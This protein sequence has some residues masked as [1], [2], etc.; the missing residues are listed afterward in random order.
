[1]GLI[2]QSPVDAH[3]RGETNH[4]AGSKGNV[5][6]VRAYGQAVLARFSDIKVPDDLKGHADTFKKAHLAY[7]NASTKVDAAREKRDA[8][9]DAIGD[10]DEL[11]DPSVHA[12]ADAMVGARMG[13]RQNP[14]S[15][16]SK[17][18]P[19]A[20]AALAYAREPEAM[21]ELAAA[22]AKK[23]PPA[24]VK[25]TVATCL[26]HAGAIEGGLKKLTAPQAAYTKALADRDALLPDWTKALRRLKKRAEAVWEDEAG[27]FKAVFAKVGAV[28]APKKRR[29]PPGP[30]EAT[31]TPAPE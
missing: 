29:I 4:M 30:P 21:R 26:K 23:S 5:G 13:K 2:A 28:Q 12:L 15:G 8:A 18:S 11:F 27:T 25:A 31:G 19:S 20:L 17:H 24:E 3:R 1:M 14:F 22:I 10:A 6:E 9:L 16:M 7:E